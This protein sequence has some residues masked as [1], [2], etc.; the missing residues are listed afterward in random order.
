MKNKI[1]AFWES[2][3]NTMPAYLQLCKFTWQMNI[4]D[5]EINILNYSN[6]HHYI[7]DTYDLEMLKKIPLAMQSDIISAAVLEKFGGIFLDIDCIITENIFEYFSELPGNKLIGF[8]YPSKGIHLAVLYAKNPNNS[9]LTYWRKKAQEKLE[10]LPEKYDWDFFGNSIINPM[11]QSEEYKNDF[12]IIDRTE[13]GNI[14]ESKMMI[15]STWKNANEYYKNFY[16]NPNFLLKDNILENVK[17]G[18]ISL[19]NSWSPDYI[20]KEYNIKNLLKHNIPIVN[21]FKKIL[22]ESYCKKDDLF[23]MKIWLGVNL[24]KYNI[25][26][27]YR[28]INEILVID[29]WYKDINIAFDIGEENGQY[30]LDI[31]VR[32]NVDAITV[33]SKKIQINFKSNKANLGIYKNKESL[34]LKIHEVF[35]FLNVNS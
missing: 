3:N 30:K 1:F 10:N 35:D 17:F 21:I 13:S 24:N 27:V 26:I 32:N 20:K 22:S 4:P 7:G 23:F 5:L 15:D 29:Y 34:L 9:V 6:L 2:P 16:F 28:I 8:G 31:L 12:L 25:K 14:L 11:I 33:V 19:H 18:I